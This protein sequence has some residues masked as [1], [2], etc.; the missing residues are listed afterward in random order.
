MRCSWSVLLGEVEPPG[1]GLAGLQVQL[2]HDAPDEL[3][4][5]GH[6]PPGELCV[7]ASV[8]VGFV[9]H[10]ECVGDEHASVVPV[11][12]LVNDA[13]RFFQSKNP[14]GDTDSQVHIFFTG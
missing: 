11:V 6:A 4:P 8:A 14:D 13:G 9:G 10:R 1:P 5:A 7:D 3:G 12:R 2:A